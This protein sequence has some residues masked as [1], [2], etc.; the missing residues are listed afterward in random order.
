[1]EPPE[2]L[3]EAE[4]AE[5]REI[6]QSMPADYFRPSDAPLLAAF[7]MASAIY[8][9]AGALIAEK[10]LI[11]S[12]PSGRQMANPASAVLTAQA[13]SMAQMAGKL[14]LC[15]SSRYNA[16]SANTKANSVGAGSKPW[17]RSA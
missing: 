13:S 1:M 5:W 17:E 4:A 2:F 16:K 8:K 7:C 6:V 15:P 3:G 12:D 9:Q 14:R 11:I 10:G